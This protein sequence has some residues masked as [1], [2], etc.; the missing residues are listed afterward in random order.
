MIVCTHSED[1]SVRCLKVE[2]ITDGDDSFTRKTIVR[3]GE[4]EAG[5]GVEEV[6]KGEGKLSMGALVER[7]C[8]CDRGSVRG[9]ECVHTRVKREG[10][11]V[12][13]GEGEIYTAEMKIC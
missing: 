13:R 8:M 6:L 11:C 9:R 3:D 10:M 1:V 5:R 4:W 2:R 7:V 12:G